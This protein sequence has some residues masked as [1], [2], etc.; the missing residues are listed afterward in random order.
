MLDEY[1]ILC[2]PVGITQYIGND[3]M[4]TDFGINITRSFRTNSG[5]RL[6]DMARKLGVTSSFLSNVEHGRKCPPDGF[7]KKIIKA[8]KLNAREA[9]RVTTEYAKCR[10]DFLIHANSMVGKKTAAMFARTIEILPDEK[11][12]EIQNI[13]IEESKNHE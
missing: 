3:S 6:S 1:H 10:T 7:D 5:E 9:M 12:Q 4:L 8:Y 13:L 11:L 2:F